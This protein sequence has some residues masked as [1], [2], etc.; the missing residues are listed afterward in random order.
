MNEP[1][2]DFVGF[3]GNLKCKDGGYI[4]VGEWEDN[5]L[6]SYYQIKKC[7]IFKILL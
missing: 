7:I 5:S 3:I 4:I 6:F 2:Y 1:Y